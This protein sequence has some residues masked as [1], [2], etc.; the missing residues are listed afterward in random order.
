MSRNNW[1]SIERPELVSIAMRRISRISLY[2]DAFSGWTAPGPR[3]V[4]SNITRCL[5]AEYAFSS[6][7]AIRSVLLKDIENLDTRGSAFRA[8]ID[9]LKLHKVS[10]ASSCHH[11]FGGRVDRVTLHSVRARD[12]H[13]ACLSADHGWTRLTIRSSH[14]ENIHTYGITGRIDH[15]IIADSRLGTIG[16]RGVELA[17]STFEMRT[18]EVTELAPS[19][20]DI[21]F[22]H[23]AVLETVSIA[24]LGPHAFS[25]L[26]SH[27]DS[28]EATLTIQQLLLADVQLNSLSFS[29]HTPVVLRQV[30]VD[31][32]C[33]CDVANQT[34][35]DATPRLLNA[36]QR[37]TRLQ[38]ALHVRCWAHAGELSSIAQFYRRNCSAGSDIPTARLQTRALGPWV[39]PVAVG[40]PVL[41]A[42]LLLLFGAA[43]TA[44]KWRRR[45]QRSAA[46]SRIHTGDC[47]TTSSAPASG[48]VEPTGNTT[49]GYTASGPGD[50]GL[51]SEIQP[52]HESSTDE[53]DTVPGDEEPGYLNPVPGDE[54]PGYLNPVPEEEEP[55]CLDLVHDDEEPEYFGLVR[56]EPEYSA[57]LPRPP[58]SVYLEMTPLSRP[59]R[60][61]R[62][63]NER[64]PSSSRPTPL[65][66][67]QSSA[68]RSEVPSDSVASRPCSSLYY[69]LKPRTAKRS[70][71]KM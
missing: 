2:I 39:W 30:T 18:S 8:N 12:V 63:L 37:V 51:S 25:Q 26:R 27:N 31:S 67:A 15:V 57:I 71:S 10:L 35:G 17:V 16:T 28:R 47:A 13:F 24:S 20:L 38:I 53:H 29:A 41:V 40:S 1:T 69:E 3:I 9:D 44:D 42:V 64:C 65:I 61:H 32:P 52:S 34:V 46:V 14:L 19:A 54:E 45:H 4:I 5:I 58:S 21:R 55:E 33:D 7:S 48:D 62:A 68:L 50:A 70:V 43:L 56:D 36:R 60:C 49:S 66:K 11:S 23:S 22:N 59:S 6:D